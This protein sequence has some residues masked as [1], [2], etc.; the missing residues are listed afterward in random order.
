M[1]VIQA[2]YKSK[3]IKESVIPELVIAGLANSGFFTY[4]LKNEALVQKEVMRL[5]LFLLHII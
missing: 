5:C 1:P 2:Y 4:I 3:Q